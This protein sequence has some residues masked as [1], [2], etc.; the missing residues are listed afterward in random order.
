MSLGL[1]LDQPHWDL[2]GGK[3]YSNFVHCKGL[4]IRAMGSNDIYISIQKLIYL[5]EQASNMMN[6]EGY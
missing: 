6:P 3:R 4:V 1:S 5:I 2:L